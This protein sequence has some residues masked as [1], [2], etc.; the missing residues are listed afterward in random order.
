MNDV[1]LGPVDPNMPLKEGPS[2][3]SQMRGV[4]TPED[5]TPMG[6]EVDPNLEFFQDFT[7][8]DGKLDIEALEAEGFNKKDIKA[9]KDAMKMYDD[10]VSLTG[11][12]RYAK[13]QLT[14]AAKKAFQSKNDRLLEQ[15]IKDRGLEGPEADAYRKSVKDAEFQQEAINQRGERRAKMEQEADAFIKAR[16]QKEELERQAKFL[17]NNPFTS[18]GKTQEELATL[19][20]VIEE[21]KPKKKKKTEK[22]EEQLKNKFNED[23]VRKR[24]GEV[25]KK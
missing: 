23:P 2:L 9:Y 8:E 14:R 12:D 25:T 21:V 15:E 7:T 22:S 4:P 10:N 24:I 6:P 11:D 16:K 3:E 1:D 5:V 17:E 13:G 20:T 18:K 19:N